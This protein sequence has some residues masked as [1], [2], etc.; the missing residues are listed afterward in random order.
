[1]TKKMKCN[2]HAPNGKV[3]DSSWEYLF[4]QYLIEKRFLIY[5]KQI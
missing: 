5:I 3:Y 2:Y 4:E 1:M